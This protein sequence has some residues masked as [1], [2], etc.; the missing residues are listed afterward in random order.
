[1]A[2]E[3][4]MDIADLFVVTFDSSNKSFIAGCV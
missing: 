3:N 1:M 2:D 4:G